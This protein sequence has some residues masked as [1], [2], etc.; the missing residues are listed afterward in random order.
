MSL[1]SNSDS[2]MDI[3]K[4][5][6]YINSMLQNKPMIF[7]LQFTTYNKLLNIATQYYYEYLSNWSWW[8]G[9]LV[10]ISSCLQWKIGSDVSSSAKIHP[11]AQISVKNV[12]TINN[13]FNYMII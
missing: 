8:Y 3:K 11:I 1:P 7:F 13:L 12:K 5:I 4:Y 2:E 6:T 10:L 9:L